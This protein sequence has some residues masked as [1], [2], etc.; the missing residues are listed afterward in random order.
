MNLTKFLDNWNAGN[1][2]FLVA[3]INLSADNQ[4]QPMQ[5]WFVYC[6]VYSTT[7]L[8]LLKFFLAAR[9]EDTTCNLLG[10]VPEHTLYANKLQFYGRTD[11]VG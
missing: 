7:E 6:R 8:L 3:F 10:K 9:E 5:Q 4:K 11:C 2:F 1:V